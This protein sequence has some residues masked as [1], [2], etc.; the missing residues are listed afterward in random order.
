[1]RHAKVGWWSLRR[2]GDQ[3][4]RGV[5]WILADSV[6]GVFIIA[7]FSLTLF[8]IGSDGCLIIGALTR[9]ADGGAVA[10]VRVPGG[11]GCVAVVGMHAII[12]GA[13]P[14]TAGVFLFGL[15]TLDTRGGGFA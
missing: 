12:A 5:R 13:A 9:L 14:L 8:L 4:W 6:G 11:R 3:G 15:R 10:V 7:A 2:G 1:M